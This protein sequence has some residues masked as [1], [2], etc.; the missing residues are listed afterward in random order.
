MTGGAATVTFVPVDARDAKTLAL[1][2][3]VVAHKAEYLAGLD[4]R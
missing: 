1:L 3:D 2:S 4:A